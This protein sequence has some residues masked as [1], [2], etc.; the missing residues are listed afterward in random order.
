MPIVQIPVPEDG[1]AGVVGVSEVRAA[2]EGVE[3][4]ELRL[5]IVDLGMVSGVAVDGDTAV[6]AVA[7]PLPG[8][9][10][11]QAV[12]GAVAEAV[13]AAT[14]AQRVEVDLR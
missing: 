8:D 13:L 10:R 11:A 1:E 12:H 6:V 5:P 2:L 7:L 9:E 4:P 3:E 14:D